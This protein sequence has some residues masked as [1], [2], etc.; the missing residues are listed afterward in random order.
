VP[1]CANARAGVGTVLN[2]FDC[3]AQVEII[4]SICTLEPDDVV[5][6]GTPG[7]VGKAL[8]KLLVPGDV[9]RVELDGIGAIESRVVQEQL[10]A[11]AAVASV[12]LGA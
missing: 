11:D 1:D 4:S 12:A 6:T 8:G 9:I 2:K 10:P 7:G 3:F 5:A